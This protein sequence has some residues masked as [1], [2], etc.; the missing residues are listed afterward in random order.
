MTSVILTLIADIV[1]MLRYPSM[2]RNSP[3]GWIL[4]G[5]V[6]SLMLLEALKEGLSTDMNIVLFLW[7][8]FIGIEGTGVVLGYFLFGEFLGLFRKG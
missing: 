2:W 1:A 6:G 7:G 4:A 8:I 3:A 5:L